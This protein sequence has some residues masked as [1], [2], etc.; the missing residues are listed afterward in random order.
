MNHNCPG[1]I[2]FKKQMTVKQS[3]EYDGLIATYIIRISP[4]SKSNKIQINA[5]FGL[6][7]GTKEPEIVTGPQQFGWGFRLI[8]CPFCGERL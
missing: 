2:E 1:M 4:V 8:Y 5:R 7:A 6:I 3:P